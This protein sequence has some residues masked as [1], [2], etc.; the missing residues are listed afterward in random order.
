MPLKCLLTFLALSASLTF[1][2]AQSTNEPIEFIPRRFLKNEAYKK[3]GIEMTPVQLIQVFRDDTNM[4]AHVKPMAWTYAGKTLLQATGTVLILWPLT[5]LLYN[6]NPNW[7]LAYIGAACY[8]VAIPL[9][10]NFS[11]RARAAIDY[12][13]SGYQKPNRVGL[14]LQMNARGIGLALQF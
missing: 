7:T 9:Q 13:N 12:Y 8:L 11:K 1:G 2:F 4:T 14:S 3:C 5:E 6:D 10:N